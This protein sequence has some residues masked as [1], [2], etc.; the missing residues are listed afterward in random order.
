[1]WVTPY[2]IP[3]Y[4]KIY[5]KFSKRLI[6]DIEDNILI[7]KKNNINPLNHLLKSQNKILYLIQS[8][9]KIIASSPELSLTCNNITKTN[10]S[11]Y[12]SPSINLKR[13]LPVNRYSNKEIIKLGWTGTFTSKEYL[14]SLEK[15]FY[16]LNKEIEFK[17]IVISNFEYSLD[18]INVDSINWNKDTEIEDLS[19]IDI[20]LYPL[21]D[22]DWISG[23]S[24][25]KALQYMAMGLPAVASNIGNNINIIQHMHNGILVKT[26]EEWIYNLKLLI[27]DCALRKKLGYNARKTIEN[28]YSLDKNSSK[29][30]EILNN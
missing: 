28:H 25:L 9:D 22:D 29:Y 23:K 7:I 17:L 5:R 13:Y 1:M 16:E 12:I 2:G 14:D 4:E 6:Y 24:G 15:V 30:L 21:S 20:G 10:K 11:L 8:S 26:K 19:K 3:I 27:S 18:F